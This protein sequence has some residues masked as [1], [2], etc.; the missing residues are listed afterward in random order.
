MA[1]I[2]LA[3]LRDFLPSQG[4]RLIAAPD[5]FVEVWRTERIEGSELLLP[6]EQAADKEFATHYALSKLAELNKATFEEL[7]RIIR[8]H[9][10]NTISIR[11]AHHDVSDGSIPL[12]DGILLNAN[13]K[14]LLIAAANA[15]IERRP[16]YQGRLPAPV[17]SLIQSAR[18]GQTT[19][20]SYVIHVFCKDGVTLADQQV[21]FARITTE[22]LHTAL[23]SLRDAVEVYE[24]SGN[25]IAFQVALGQGAS[26]NLCEA[27]ANFSGKDRSRTVEISLQPSAIDRLISP[28]RTTVTFLPIH[29][30][31]I[32]AAAAYFRETYTLHNETVSG[33]IERLSR[34][35]EQQDGSI[36]I[37]TTLSSGAQRSVEVQL[38]AENYPDAIHAHE[39]KVHVRVTGDVVVT[40]RSAHVIAPRD[41]AVIGNRDLFDSTE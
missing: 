26:A 27:I 36:R 20:G 35:A 33:V 11:V 30:T 23:V 41:F 39:N 17:S 2:K 5:A 13:A 4:W 3:Q 40:P 15:A 8:E 7:E 6:T 34:R 32:R 37:A 22:T 24:D 29:Q 16:L 18:L 31:G 38:S 19:H 12:D 1:S 21:S 10:D 28:E 25:P 9:C 14:D